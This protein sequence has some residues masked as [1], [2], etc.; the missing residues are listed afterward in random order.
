[1]DVSQLLSKWADARNTISALEKKVDQ[2]KKIMASHMQKNDIAKY[3]D[4]FFIVRQTTQNRSIITKKSVPSEIWEAYATPH[5]TRFLL[6]TEK[7]AK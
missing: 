3:E 2:Y 7:K 1:M 5:T 6:L 4:D